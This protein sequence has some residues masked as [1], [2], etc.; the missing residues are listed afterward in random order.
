MNYPSHVKKMLQTWSTEAYRREMERELARLE[1]DIDAWKRD[2]ISSEE[3][4]HRVHAWDAGP[5]KALSKQYDYGHPDTNVAFA[6]VAGILKEKELPAEMLE[7]I[8]APLEMYRAMKSTGRLA[9]R[10]GKWWE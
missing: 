7:A 10:K 3:L 2:R 8:A 5:S 1:Q 4:S 6:V 9:S